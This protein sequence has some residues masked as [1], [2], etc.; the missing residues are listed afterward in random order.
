MGAYV[1][2]TNDRAVGPL[3]VHRYMRVC[4]WLDPGS[5]VFGEGVDAVPEGSTRG[6]WG[7]RAAIEVVVCSF[8]LPWW[9]RRWPLFFGAG[10]PDMVADAAGDTSVP[11]CWG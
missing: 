1:A 4:V 5:L 2:C 11:L 8:G 3:L 9:W 7:M 10:G 6:A